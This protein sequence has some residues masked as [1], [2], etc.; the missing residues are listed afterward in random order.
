MS[1][2]TF[3]FNILTILLLLFIIVTLRK[4]IKRSMTKTEKDEVIVDTS[5]LIDGRILEVLNTGFL[6]YKL[7]VPEF[8]IKELQKVA[9]SED[10]LRRQRGRKGLKTLR[11]LQKIEGV[12]SEIIEDDF[13]TITYVDEKIVELAK[14]KNY[15]ILTVDYNLN[16]VAKV[17]QLQVL[18]INELAKNLRPLFLPGEEIEVKIV[19]KGKEGSQGV[20][21]LEDGTMVGVEDGRRFLGNKLKCLV[22]RILQTDAGR[23]VFA[24]PKS[25]GLDRVGAPKQFIRLPQILPWQRKRPNN[26]K[27]NHY[28]QGSQNHNHNNNI[29]NNNKKSV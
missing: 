19:Q 24:R 28:Y 5:T 10:P 27:N 1:E 25:Y 9:D 26:F 14:T 29:N 18:N 4:D 8:V 22:S 20:G 13:S 7:I 17:H 23:M 3:I 11:S 15:K 21:Y 2:V 16:N 12:N 6:S